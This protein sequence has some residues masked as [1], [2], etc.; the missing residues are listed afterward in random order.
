MFDIQHHDLP[1]CCMSYSL[2]IFFWRPSPASCW[3]LLILL[4][5]GAFGNVLARRAVR[6]RATA[7]NFSANSTFNWRYWSSRTS[8]EFL[9]HLRCVSLSVHLQSVR[10]AADQSILASVCRRGLISLWRSSKEVVQQRITNRHS[11]LSCCLPISSAADR[12]AKPRVVR[13]SV[14]ILEREDE[15]AQ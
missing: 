7:T 13:W 5:T 2:C 3:R 4:S 6:R 1:K 11:I 8:E 10:Q 15:T 9:W 14:T 12:N